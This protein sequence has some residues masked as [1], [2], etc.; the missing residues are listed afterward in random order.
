MAAGDSF[1]SRAADR[2]A[3]G[4]ERLGDLAAAGRADEDA[5]ALV[6]RQLGLL[7]G[8]GSVGAEAED[9]AARP[10][11]ERVALAGGAGKQFGG[12]LDADALDT[13]L[14]LIDRRDGKADGEPGERI[15]ADRRHE[16]FERAPENG[17]DSSTAGLGTGAATALPPPK[18]CE[19][20]TAP[21]WLRLT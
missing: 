15:D 19:L 3:I 17:A 13:D 11:V 12:G 14:D 9:D 6:E 18:G 21:I 20:T 7:M 2:F 5:I 1:L 16:G 8:A 4:A 10:G